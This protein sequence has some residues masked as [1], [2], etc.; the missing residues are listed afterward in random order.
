MK[1]LKYKRNPAESP[2]NYFNL[3]NTTYMENQG[4]ILVANI[5]RNNTAKEIVVKTLLNSSNFQ[6]I[7]KMFS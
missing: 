3:T 4:L 5:S 7:D 1:E 6:G 2:N